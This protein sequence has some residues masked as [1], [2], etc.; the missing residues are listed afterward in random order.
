MLAN[1][2]ADPEGIPK[3]HSFDHVYF[4]STEMKYF[5]HVDQPLD[6][7]WLTLITADRNGCRQSVSFVGKN[8]EYN[9]R[10]C[11]RFTL[12][13]DP[14]VSTQILQPPYFVKNEVFNA[15]PFPSNCVSF[16]RSSSR[17]V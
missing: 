3:A 11:Q 16:C 13:E 10:T 4:S 15:F 1:R 12:T 7:N 5:N 8:V 17:S 2:A 9:L 6:P 14:L